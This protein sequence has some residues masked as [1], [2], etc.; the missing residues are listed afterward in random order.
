MNP[1]LNR[2]LYLVKEHLGI[3]KAANNFDIFDPETGALIIEC[4]EEGM[5]FLTK[6]L[7]F[8]DAKQSTPFNIYLRE[9]VSGWLI[10]SVSRG[11]TFWRSKVTVH[12]EN[13]TPI[14]WF[15]QKMFTIGGAFEL[16]TMDDRLVATLQGKWTGWEFKFK[17]ETGELAVVTKKWAGLGQELFTTAD[18][19]M[20]SISDMVRQNDPA[21]L[22][23]L[24]SVVCIDMVLKEK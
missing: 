15:R 5:S 14:G 9:P 2:N 4:R 11:F 1:I 7:R 24:A 21:R 17:S 8:T 6:F 13:G 19:Y 3:F 20:I 10:L 12:D 23:I 18:T 16:Y 22:I